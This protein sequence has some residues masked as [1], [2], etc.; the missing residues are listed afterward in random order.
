MSSASFV[1]RTLTGI[2]EIT[3]SGKEDVGTGAKLPLK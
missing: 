3:L 1:E 2:G